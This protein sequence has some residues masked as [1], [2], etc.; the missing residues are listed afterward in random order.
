[1]GSDLYWLNQS[2][3]PVK[4]CGGRR[5]GRG[6]PTV[7]TVEHPPLP[8]GPMVENAIR[9]SMVCIPVKQWCVNLK[10]FFCKIHLTI[11]TLFF[12][13]C[14]RRTRGEKQKILDRQGIFFFKLFTGGQHVCRDEH[15][16]WRISTNR[17]RLPCHEYCIFKSRTLSIPEKS[18]LCSLPVLAPRSVTTA[19]T[20][21]STGQL[22]LFWVL[23]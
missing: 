13:A 8:H 6:L 1:M 2:D 14:S 5:A 21:N 7:F 19:L 3:P 18:P 20:L 23:Y 9:L 10:A 22:C 4:V 17:I 16:A 11:E 15:I 12:P